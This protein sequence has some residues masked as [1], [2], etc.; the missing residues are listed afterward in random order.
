MYLGEGGFGRVYRTR[1]QGQGTTYD[2]AVKD[3]SLSKC[4]SPESQLLREV[5]IG[6][7]ASGCP[8]A[9]ATYGILQ[10]SGNI[11][12]LMELMDVSVDKFARKVNLKISNN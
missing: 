6:K 4:D 5:D 10:H 11:R 9:V 1:L 8:F 12:I 3:I 2:I 7:L